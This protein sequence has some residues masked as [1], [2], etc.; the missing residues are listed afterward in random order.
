MNSKPLTNSVAKLIG[1]NGNAFIIL[2]RVSK[3]I[4]KSD[5]PELVDEFNNEAI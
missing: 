1:S 4:Q 2:W 5:K 3:A